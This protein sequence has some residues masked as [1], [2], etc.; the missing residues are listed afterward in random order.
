MKRRGYVRL[1]FAAEL[2]RSALLRRPVI[3]KLDIRDSS[4]ELPPIGR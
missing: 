4:A 3:A 1:I 2:A